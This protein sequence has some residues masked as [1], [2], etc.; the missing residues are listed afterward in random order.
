MSIIYDA[1]KKS[2]KTRAAQPQLRTTPFKFKKLDR[3]NTII[4][5]LIMTCLFVIAATLALPT[6]SAST[7]L[8]GDATAVKPMTARTLKL[9]SAPRLMLEGVFLSDNER[10]A[11]IN[12]RTYHEGDKV[13]GMRI[14]NIALDEVTLQNK[15]RSL[16]LRNSIAQLN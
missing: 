7:R 14:V 9:A 2:Q 11:M 5:L 8:Y 6:P 4:S 3:K 16:V 1:L 12:H 15:K 10:L 13:N